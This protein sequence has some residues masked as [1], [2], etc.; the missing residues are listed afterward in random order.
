MLF[1]LPL[2]TSTIP[3]Q[4]IGGIEVEYEASVSNAPFSGD[5]IEIKILS[6]K[7]GDCDLLWMLSKSVVRA[8]AE[9]NFLNT[10]ETINQ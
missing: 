5:G 10:L 3:P 2:T 1:I 9:N 8:A 7:L 6:A 4:H